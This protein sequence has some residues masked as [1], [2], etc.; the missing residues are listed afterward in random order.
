MKINDTVLDFIEKLPLERKEKVELKSSYVRSCSDYWVKAREE[1]K[2]LGAERLEAK[3]ERAITRLLTNEPV[4]SIFP[5]DNVLKDYAQELRLFGYSCEAVSRSFKRSIS[6]TW[7]IQ[8]TEGCDL[9]VR[10]QVIELLDDF[11]SEFDLSAWLLL[12]SYNTNHG[13]KLTK[14]EK[15]KIKLL[16][17]Q[18][19]SIGRISEKIG[20]S[21]SSV[22]RW[23]SK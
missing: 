21:Q 20:R 6:T 5:I 18:G 1:I 17:S 9:R 22:R 12:G 15:A 14:E 4:N 7:M 23:V 8:H 16:Y 3:K 11:I 13:P 19:W 2:I 10:G